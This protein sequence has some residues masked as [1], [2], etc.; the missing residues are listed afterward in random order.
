MVYVTMTDSFMSGWGHAEN[1]I[2]KLIFECKDLKEAHVVMDNAKHRADMKYI[3]LCYK[4][5]YYNKNRYYAQI[6]TNQDYSSWY[7]PNFF[8]KSFK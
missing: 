8:N 7:K 1:K 4:K 3:D 5:P 6:K 2:N